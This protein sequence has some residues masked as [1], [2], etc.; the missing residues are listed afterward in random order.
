MALT[1]EGA[2]LPDAAVTASH[3]GPALFHRSKHEKFLIYLN[4]FVKKYR[5]E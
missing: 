1:A 5:F 2:G 3:T 4:G